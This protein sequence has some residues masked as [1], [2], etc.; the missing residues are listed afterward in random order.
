MS[1]MYSVAMEVS[2]SCLV[3]SMYS[4]AMEVSDSGLQIL[5]VNLQYA[6]PPSARQTV[7][8][9]PVALWKLGADS[10]HGTCIL[11]KWGVWSTTVHAQ[12]CL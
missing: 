11:Q 10:H 1:G 5:P 3:G 12:K 2:D 9:Q 7:V 4:V 6:P 8:L